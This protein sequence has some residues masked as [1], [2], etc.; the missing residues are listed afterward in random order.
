[1]VRAYWACACL[2]LLLCRSSQSH[3]GRAVLQATHMRVNNCVVCAECGERS[4]SACR[5]SRRTRCAPCQP[6]LRTLCANP[7]II[8]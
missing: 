1:M 2:L 5:P 4:R 6:H 8:V 7:V 3:A